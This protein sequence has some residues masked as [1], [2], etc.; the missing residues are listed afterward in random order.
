MIFATFIKFK[1]FGRLRNLAIFRP[2][3]NLPIY[4]IYFILTRSCG[5][6]PNKIF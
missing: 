2:F 3:H 6:A 5:V 1:N 4:F